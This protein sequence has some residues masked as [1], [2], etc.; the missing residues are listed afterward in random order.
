MSRILVKNVDGLR[1]YGCD[2]VCYVGCHSDAA[3]PYSVAVVAGCYAGEAN[4]F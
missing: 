4:V 3:C 1:R 2:D